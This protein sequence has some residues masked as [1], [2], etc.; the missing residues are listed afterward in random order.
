MS[1]WVTLAQTLSQNVSV[2]RRVCVCCVFSART[3]FAG[4]QHRRL[5]CCAQMHGQHGFSVWIVYF[6]LVEFWKWS[7]LKVNCAPITINAWPVFLSFGRGAQ[8]RFHFRTWV[9]GATMP[10][11]WCRCFVST[12]CWL[13]FVVF[14]IGWMSVVGRL[15]RIVL[16][17]V[18]LFF[19]MCVSVPNDL[20]G[21]YCTCK[22]FVCTSDS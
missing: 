22:C 1:P 16:H 11:R 12:K 4:T 17:R 19:R 15:S 10:F 14:Y 5:I 13:Y 8:M 21:F 9:L 20:C 7:L 3:R 18:L 6:D 2:T